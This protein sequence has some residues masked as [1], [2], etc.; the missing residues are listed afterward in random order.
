[1]MRAACIYDFHPHYGHSRDLGGHLFTG[2]ERDTE[3]GNDYFEAR[4]YASA[5]GR[6]MS[7]DWSAK[8]EP[9]PYAKLG[10]PQT[11]NLYAYVLNN[12]LIYADPDGHCPPGTDCS[13]IT[14]TAEVTKQPEITSSRSGM[15]STATARAEVQYTI[16]NGNQAMA[17]TPVK[18]EVSNKSYQ[19]G[20]QIEVPPTTRDDST[21]DKGVI[22]D[23]S[24][25]SLTVSVPS[26]PGTNA[27]EQT[28][29]TGDFSKVTT[30]TLKVG[31]CSVTEQRTLSVKD[32]D[33]KLTFQTP[34]TQK[35]TPVKV[36]K[37]NSSK[38]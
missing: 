17:D 16:K 12:P 7:P 31:S 34:A 27:A 2:K 35:M 30:Q 32:G 13:K 37:S 1:M 5:L 9:V 10:D 28:M 25:I 24:T 22:G 29:L 33:A 15:S 6:F 18:E 4:Y 36:P 38:P 11:L 3:S 8:E 14:V 21:N 23:E 20:K 19:D 26:L